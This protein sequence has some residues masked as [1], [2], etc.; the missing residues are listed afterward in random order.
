[1]IETLNYEAVA[2]FHVLS[3]TLLSISQPFDTV[4]FTDLP[5]NKSQYKVFRYVRLHRTE[6]N[7]RISMNVKHHNTHQQI[8]PSFSVCITQTT[9]L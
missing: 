1:M 4:S 9:L 2:S 3:E 7:N 6:A 5:L 8:I